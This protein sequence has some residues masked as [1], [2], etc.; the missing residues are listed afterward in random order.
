[1]WA[2]N[3]RN[4]FRISTL[5]LRGLHN[6]PERA[7]KSHDET[8]TLITM[9]RDA[10]THLQEREGQDLNDIVL[11]VED[12]VWQAEDILSLT[13]LDQSGDEAPQRAEMDR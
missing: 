7:A 2:R 5:F 11:N 13:R 4:R 1:M 9:L 12:G 10:R 8:Q 6:A 3:F